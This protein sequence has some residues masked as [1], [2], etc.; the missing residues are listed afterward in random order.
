MLGAF[1]R[2]RENVDYLDKAVVPGTEKDSP[3][4]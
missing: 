4:Y 2:A 3:N 1:G